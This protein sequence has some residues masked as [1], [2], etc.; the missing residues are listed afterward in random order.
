MIIFSEKKYA[1]GLLADGF[2]NFMSFKDLSILAKYYAYTGE[3]KAKISQLLYAFCEKWNEEFND[4]IYYKMIRNAVNSTNKMNLRIEMPVKI[5]Q[6]ELNFI[7]TVENIDT[8]KVLFCMLVLAK[9]YHENPVRKD[10]KINEKYIGRYYVNIK[11]NE[12]LKMAKVYLK[13]AER[14]ALLHSMSVLGYIKETFNGGY[15]ILYADVASTE[16]VIVV[17]DL[18][19]MVSFLPFYCE[20]C[21]KQIKANKRHSKCSV[22]YQKHRLNEAKGRMRG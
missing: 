12:I 3:N 22:C 14:N 11:F 4:V 7:K 6:I 2:K 21:G 17:D 18:D 9:F 5:S 16:H 19:N 20:D 15:E 8:Q 1:E 13:K 10:P